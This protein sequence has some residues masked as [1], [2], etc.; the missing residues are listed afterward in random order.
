MRKIFMAFV[1]VAAFATTTFGATREDFTLTDQ[2]SVFA[3][4]EAVDA[5]NFQLTR[6]PA[7]VPQFLKRQGTN[8]LFTEDALT[9]PGK[10]CPCDGFCT[11]SVSDIAVR[12]SDADTI[13]YRFA[14]EV[15]HAVY[16]ATR[17]KWGAE[18][19]TAM[20]SLVNFYRETGCVQE[21]QNSALFTEADV[22]DECF[23]RCYA[24]FY[25]SCTIET[26]FPGD[27]VKFMHHVNDLL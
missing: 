2:T 21:I 9:C 17:S 7:A 15:G 27:V 18:E 8:I 14:H 16:Y 23:A 25:G 5:F 4:E 1:F 24:V 26:I 11:Y 12:G 22:E 20:R 6:M 19:K 13:A 10:D 3:Q